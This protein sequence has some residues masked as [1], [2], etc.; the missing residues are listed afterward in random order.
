[1]VE[2]AW[3]PR[4]A[5]VAD[6]LRDNFTRGELGAGVCVVVGGRTVVD[7]WAGWADEAR[8]RPW[9]RDTVVDV[10]SAAKPLAAVLVLRAGVDPATRVAALWPE[11]AAQGKDMVSVEHVLTPRAGLPAIG[12]PL[13]PG[14]SYDWERMCG[15]LAGQE[16]WWEPGTAHGYHVNTY[17]FLLGE[18]A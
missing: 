16:P 5:G 17:G 14:S 9:T 8:K 15:A 10:F 7:A 6:A 12:E 1:M 3:D 4:F 18:I 11:F 2:G 13:P